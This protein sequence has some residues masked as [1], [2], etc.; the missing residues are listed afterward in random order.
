[1]KRHLYQLYD[2]RSFTFACPDCDATIPYLDVKIGFKLR[3]ETDFFQC[4]NCKSLLCV[5]RPYA[6]SVFLGTMGV[7]VGVVEVLRVHPMW[8]FAVA[9][10]LAWVLVTIRRNLCE[11]VVPSEDLT[12]LLG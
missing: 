6:W 3:Y 11:M 4:A 5:S 7:S 8:L 9:A 2:I 10:L 12:L 1:M